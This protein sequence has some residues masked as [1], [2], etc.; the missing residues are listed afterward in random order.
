MKLV[1]LSLL[2]ASALCQANLTGLDCEYIPQK[3]SL[4]DI[5]KIDILDDVKRE[6][7][8]CGTEFSAYGTCCSLDSLKT[9]TTA[10]N[11]NLV[12]GVSTLKKEYVKFA[13][14]IDTINSLINDVADSSP[15]PEDQLYTNRINIAKTIRD[16]KAIN[17]LKT[18]INSTKSGDFNSSLDK[19]WGD[20]SKVRNSALCTLCTGRSSAFV[21]NQNNVVIQDSDCSD[22]ANKCKDSLDNLRTFSQALSLYSSVLNPLLP[23]TLSIHTDVS[24]INRDNLAAIV[25]L[26][27]SD[28]VQ[29]SLASSNAQ[30]NS[31]LCSTV[32]SAGKPVLIEAFNTVFNPSAD[33]TLFSLDSSSNIKIKAVIGRTAFDRDT[34][35]SNMTSNLVAPAQPVTADVTKMI[36]DLSSRFN[37]LTSSS[38]RRRLQV[39]TNRVDTASFQAMIDELKNAASNSLNADFFGVTPTFVPTGAGLSFG[40]TLNKY[41]SSN[42]RVLSETGYRA[43]TSGARVASYSAP[44]A[45]NPPA[46]SRSGVLDPLVLTPTTLTIS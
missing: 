10:M 43:E 34:L 33:Y 39:L 28:K 1:L 21:F 29:N 3:Q 16:S 31:D 2:V 14:A 22:I 41:M 7:S 35:L 27:N 44:P 4:Q 19:C 46:Y 13:S 30:A 40:S 15:R 26:L 42:F 32:L 38:R 36:S 6:T 20:V 37:Q 25:N 12:N 8:A 24:R 9:Q 17:F 18:S 5:L 45:N 11:N 23:S